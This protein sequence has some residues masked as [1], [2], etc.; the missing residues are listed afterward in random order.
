MTVDL[1]FRFPQLQRTLSKLD[2][3]NDSQL[4]QMAAA[5]YERAE[6]M[7]GDAKRMTPVA[8]STKS[9][10]GGTLRSTVHALKPKTGGGKFETGITAG[11]PAAPYAVI[12][13]EKPEGELRS[14]TRVRRRSMGTQWKYL[15]TPF[16]AQRREAEKDMLAAIRKGT[17]DAMR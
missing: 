13:H 7:A 1:N 10:R 11:G 14:Q 3:L 17:K 4:A 16:K 8:V 6:K 2:K 5:G 12:V 9:H 15:E